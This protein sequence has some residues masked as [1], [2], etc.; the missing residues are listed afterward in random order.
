ML[1]TLW[2]FLIGPPLDGFEQHLVDAIAVNRTRRAEWGALTD[3]AT[4][5]LLSALITSERLIRPVARAIDARAVSLVAAGVPVVVGDFV[6]MTGQLPVDTPIPPTAA[7]DAADVAA[8][9]A[10][11]AG[12]AATDPLDGFAV[13]DASVEALAALTAL[14]EA[15][16][17][18]FAMSR[19]VIE[20][21][22]LAALHG[23]YYRCESA[24]AEPVVRAL[25]STQRQGLSRLRVTD[26]DVQAN[27]FHQ[28]GLGVLI[29]DLPPIPFL[30]EAAIFQAE[31]RARLEA[32]LR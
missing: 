31:D 2:Y 14:E 22:G 6:E 8:A 24:Q 20:S 15:E 27:A 32:C 16:D 18:R 29:N 9:D 26:Y 3:G 30:A 11:I 25:V 28:Q 7:M 17:V 19:H 13:V 10:I 1:K 23:L 21:M 4:D 12:L 5:D